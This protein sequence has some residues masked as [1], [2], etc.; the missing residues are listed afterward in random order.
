M[1]LVLSLALTAILAGGLYGCS[2][3]TT[4]TTTTTE[5]TVKQSGPNSVMISLLDSSKQTREQQEYL[6]QLQNIIGSAWKPSKADKRYSVSCEF[7]VTRP[8]YLAEIHATSSSGS[9]R[10]IEAALDTVRKLAPFPA[11]PA[12]FKEAPMQFRCDFLYVPQ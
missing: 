9:H 11:L 6:L 1:R 2:K 12:S 8:G 7:T 10:R 3:E 4:T 5:T